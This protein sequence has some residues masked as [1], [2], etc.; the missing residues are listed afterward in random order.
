VRTPPAID[1]T[2]FGGWGGDCAAFTTS[3]APQLTMDTDK[4]CTVRFDA[5]TPSGPFTARGSFSFGWR[6]EGGAFTGTGFFAPAFDAPT[7]DGT[8]IDFSNLD[9][10]TSPAGPEFSTCP[11]ARTATIYFNPF[12]PYNQNVLHS[13]CPTTRNGSVTPT[14]GGITTNTSYGFEPGAVRLWP[15]TSWTVYA[16]Y[17]FGKVELRDLNPTPQTPVTIDLSPGERSCPY[18]MTIHGDTAYVVGREGVPATSTANCDNWRGMWVVNLTSQTVLD[19]VPFGINPRN[20]IYDEAQDV[21]YVT[22]FGGDKVYV[23]DPV[24]RTV[25]D[26]FD[27]GDGPVGLETTG[28]DRLLVTNWHTNLLKIFDLPTHQE[29][30]SINSGGVHPVDVFLTGTTVMVLNFGDPATSIGAVLKFFDLQ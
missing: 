6:V 30:G 26:S 10:P 13:T 21:P 12:V 29:L 16:N 14:G 22:D 25:I 8:R 1:T 23:I 7:L 5:S 19:F 4:N 3:L 28:D 15:S 2:A 11:G 17:E 18:S 27:V 9:N 24:T 20:V